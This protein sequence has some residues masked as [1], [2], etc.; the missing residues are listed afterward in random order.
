MAKQM[1]CLTFQISE[2]QNCSNIHQDI[3]SLW[4]PKKDLF[5]FLRVIKCDALIEIIEKKKSCP[6]I[7][8]WVMLVVCA[9]IIFPLYCK[10]IFTFL[11][12]LKNIF[13]FLIIY[14]SGE[15]YQN[16]EHKTFFIHCVFSLLEQ[17]WNCQNLLPWALFSPL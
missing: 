11:Y 7:L 5:L 1:A 2:R 4:N 17:K 12:T 14:D 10:T 6:N 3:T 8:V 9:I 15:N 13:S 16:M